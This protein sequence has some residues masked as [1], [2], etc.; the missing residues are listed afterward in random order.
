MFDDRRAMYDGFNKENGAHSAE[1]FRIAKEFLKLAFAGGRLQAMCPCVNCC[2]RRMLSE[3]EMS[4]HIAMKGFMP[5]Y[6]V[7]HL[8]GEAYQP[9]AEESD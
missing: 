5:D 8:H 7:W 4:G 2:N 9:T 6:L 1:W 3:F